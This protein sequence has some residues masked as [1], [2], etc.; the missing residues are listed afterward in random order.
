[1]PFPFR[2][3]IPWNRGLSEII[4]ECFPSRDIRIERRELQLLRFLFD[5][6]SACGFVVDE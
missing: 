4:R 2:T 6:E 5:L 3:R 1:V